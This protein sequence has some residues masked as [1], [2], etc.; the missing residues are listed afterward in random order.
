[1]KKSFI[2][3]EIFFALQSCAA[4]ENLR[5]RKNYMYLITN[6]ITSGSTLASSW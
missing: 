2:S 3:F 4:I 1:M 6:I 5:C